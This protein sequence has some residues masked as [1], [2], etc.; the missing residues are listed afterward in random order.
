MCRKLSLWHS[1]QILYSTIDHWRISILHFDIMR[2]NCPDMELGSH[3]FSEFFLVHMQWFIFCVH[4]PLLK[5][6]HSQTPQMWNIRQNVSTGQDGNAAEIRREYD[7]SLNKLLI[8]KWRLFDNLKGL[9]IT[10]YQKTIQ[11]FWLFCW[12]VGIVAKWRSFSELSSRLQWSW[13][14]WYHCG[15]SHSSY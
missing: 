8:R 7:F 12:G 13:C 14:W 4:E 10:Y 15:Y 9:D 5:R 11:L 1:T 3:M 2:C 6:R